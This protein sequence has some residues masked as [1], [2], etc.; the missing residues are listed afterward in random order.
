MMK[1]FL[2]AIVA[3]IAIAIT[4]NAGET[5][6]R[7][8]SVLPKA[9]QTILADNF[10]AKVSMI[11]IDKDF[12]RVSEYEVILTDGSEVTFD[13]NG[14]WKEVEVSLK[15]SVPSFF[16][17]KSVSEYIK[18]THSGQKIVGIE[19][20]RSGYEVELTNGIDLK[21]NN[22]GLFLKYD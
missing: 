3:I 20:N 9:A 10:K 22:Q 13:H 1:K 4:A 19:K 18:K 8:A 14:N 17:P 15:N 2:V 7:D 21:F 6:S 16:V 5:F 12:G 11:K